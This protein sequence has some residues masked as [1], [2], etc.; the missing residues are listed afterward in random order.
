MI[1]LL[2]QFCLE[3][4]QRYIN[5]K[6]NNLLPP[7]ITHLSLKRASYVGKTSCLVAWWTA[8]RINCYWKSWNRTINYSKIII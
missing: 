3:E 5:I 8:H 2:N 7:I 1:Q 4:N 6:S